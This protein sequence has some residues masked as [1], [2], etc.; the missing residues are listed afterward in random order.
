MNNNNTGSFAQ[1]GQGIRGNVRGYVVGGIYCPPRSIP[2]PTYPRPSN[3]E[4]SI[5]QL[6]RFT[7]TGKR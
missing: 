7:G 4:P 5:A 2:P 3:Y 1:I 6:T